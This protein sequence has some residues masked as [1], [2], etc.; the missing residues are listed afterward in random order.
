ML[1]VPRHPERFDSVADLVARA[2]FEVQRRTNPPG[3]SS[4]PVLLLDT[5][6]SLPLHTGS[7]RSL[8]SVEP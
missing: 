8:S 5:L 7:P 6:E 2:G 3:A 4:A 1:L